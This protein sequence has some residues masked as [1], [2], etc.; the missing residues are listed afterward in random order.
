MSRV[1]LFVVGQDRR[2]RE[3]PLCFGE[4]GAVLCICWPAHCPP[5]TSQSRPCMGRGGG[6]GNG[7]GMLWPGEALTVV[8]ALDGGGDDSL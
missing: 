1:R 2:V 5:P 3:K 8:G 7:G 6:V 4:G